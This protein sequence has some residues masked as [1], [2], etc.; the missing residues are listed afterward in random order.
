[1]RV[2]LA[3][4]QRVVGAEVHV[5]DHDG[6]GFHACEV[7]QLGAIELPIPV[8]CQTRT[9]WEHR[10]KPPEH[11]NRNYRYVCVLF[12]D[13]NNTKVAEGRSCFEGA[14]WG[15]VFTRQQC[16]T[17]K[18]TV[19]RR[20]GVHIHVDYVQSFVQTLS[21]HTLVSAALRRPQEQLHNEQTF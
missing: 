21:V 7:D 12:W 13:C 17:R 3:D 11:A 8:L 10:R 1:M 6:D 18:K 16:F 2:I 19:E 14:S 5:L 9:T 15:S 4:G 20:D